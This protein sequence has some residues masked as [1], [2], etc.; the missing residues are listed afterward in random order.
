[1][2]RHADCDDRHGYVGLVSGAC[3]S[4]FRARR[5]LRRPRTRAR[6]RRLR[7]GSC[8]LRSR[9][10]ELVASNV[11]AGAAYLHDRAGRRRWR[12][13]TRCFIAVG[14]PSRRGDDMRSLLRLRR[15]SRKSPPR[16]PGRSS[17]SPS[18]PCGGYRREVERLIREVAPQHRRACRLQ[19]G[20]PARGRRN[21]GFQA[22]RPESSCGTDSERRARSC[23]RCIARSIWARR[24]S[25]SLAAHLR[26]DQI[27]R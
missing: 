9:P 4:E 10:R 18:P 2:K 7:P 25:C 14:T 3:F 23:A 24:R 6:F 20:I 21:R 5:R 8:D 26:T 17:L 16:S 11:R 15:D 12:R 22:A 27:C 13:R 1:M 19:P